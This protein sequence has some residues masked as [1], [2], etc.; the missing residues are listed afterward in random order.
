[1]AQ[2]QRTPAGARLILDR[3]S[4]ITR[5]EVDRLDLSESTTAQRD[6]F[7]AL[8]VEEAERVAAIDFEA[9]HYT[10]PTIWLLTTLT[11]DVD[12]VLVDIYAI[13]AQT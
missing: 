11:E 10:G 5:I 3:R 2:K 4:R 6:A 12:D 7:T 13:E 9:V 8:A 1:M